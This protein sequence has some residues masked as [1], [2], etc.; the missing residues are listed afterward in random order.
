[1]PSSRTLDSGIDKVLAASLR[2]ECVPWPS[3]WTS[4]QAAL[5]LIERTVY[6]GLTGLLV[7]REQLLEDWPSSVL[8]TLRSQA[9][10]RAMWELRHRLVL[11][12]LLTELA[13]NGIAAVILKGTA[14]AYDLYDVPALRA[15][16]DTDLLIKRSDLARVR[17]LLAGLGF[18]RLYNAGVTTEEFSL[19]E[20]WQIVSTDGTIHDIDLHWQALNLLALEGTLNVADCFAHPMNLPRLC[21]AA[22]SMDRVLTLIHTALHRAVHITSPYF[23][24]ST[25]YYGGDRLIWAQDIHLLAQSLSI[26]DWRRLCEIA[27]D[28]GVEEVCAS[29]LH[30]A[31]DRLGTGIPDFVWD[32]L[33]AGA[34]ESSATAYILHVGQFARAWK[35]VRAI[36]SLSAKLR[37]VAGRMLPPASFMRSKY[38]AM[39]DKPLALLH[40]RRGV[41]LLRKRPERSEN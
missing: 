14:L 32:A 10:A 18:E 9:L 29:G 5:D 27:H 1:M 6:H 19:Q 17:T 7:E 21:D 28:K 31:R 26:A 2:G 30:L 36:P 16:G 23:V 13:A 37:F 11:G 34:A 39:R 22:F 24:G 8:A 38:P 41:E 35:E 20:I 3:A 25:A 15:R 4:P 12:T 40:L 33:E